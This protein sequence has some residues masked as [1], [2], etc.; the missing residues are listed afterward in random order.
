MDYEEILEYVEL[1]TLDGAVRDG[2]AYSDIIPG[3]CDGRICDCLFTFAIS[4]SSRQV[5]GPLE[6]VYF[7]SDNKEIISK[8]KNQEHKRITLGQSTDD[9]KECLEELYGDNYQRIKSLY[10]RNE[11]S[12]SVED[13][14]IVKKTI[15]ILRAN[16]GEEM[17]PWYEELAQDFIQWTNKF[18]DER[19]V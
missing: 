15:S 18:T 16:A 5:I 9:L 17:F 12:Y 3:V 10:G 2:L 14:E 4:Y 7:D 6:F 8:V 13:K 1:S 19:E 11:D